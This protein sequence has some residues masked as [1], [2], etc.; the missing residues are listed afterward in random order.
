MITTEFMNSSVGDFSELI[1]QPFDLKSP[2]CS[3]ALHL[4]YWRDA[5]QA[6]DT[7]CAALTVP[8]PVE[9]ALIF[10]HQVPLSKG[11]GGWSGP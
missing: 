3:T 10:E 11:T 2:F 6:L 1:E 7:V 8:V 5:K 4:A 9:V